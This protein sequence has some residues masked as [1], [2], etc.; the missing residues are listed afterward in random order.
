M[1]VGNPEFNKDYSANLPNSLSQEQA[2]RMMNVS[3]WKNIKAV[4]LY[5]ML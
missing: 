5:N 1:E 2:A 4:T 3:T